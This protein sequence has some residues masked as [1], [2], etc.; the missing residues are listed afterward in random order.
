MHLRWANH[1]DPNSPIFKGKRERVEVA[2]SDLGLA[3]V[4]SGLA[5]LGNTYGWLWL[6][7]MY[8]IPYLWVNNW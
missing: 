2:V 3:A 8:I 6:V 1:F 5:W 4:L 7:K